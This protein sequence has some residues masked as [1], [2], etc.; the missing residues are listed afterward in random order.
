MVHVR[1]NVI[2]SENRGSTRPQGKIGHA[3]LPHSSTGHE[4]ILTATEWVDEDVLGVSA[5]KKAKQLWK[6]FSREFKLQAITLV[7][8]NRMDMPMDTINKLVKD[9]MADISEETETKE[10]LAYEND[11]TSV[12]QRR[13]A[14]TYAVAEAWIWLHRYKQDAIIKVSSK[15]VYHSVRLVKMITNCM[16]VSC[17][18]SQWDHGNLSWSPMKRLNIMMKLR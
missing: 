11:D 1:S 6:S 16:Y 17:L 8:S 5:S 3:V 14:I 15:P 18:I 13:I 12:G 2:C 7:N 10:T 4:Y 9:K